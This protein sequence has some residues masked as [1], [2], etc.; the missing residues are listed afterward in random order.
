MDWIVYKCKNYSIIDFC[1][2][3]IYEINVYMIL[4]FFLEIINAIVFIYIDRFILVI[5]D[6]EKLNLF[7]SIPNYNYILR[8]PIGLK[9]IKMYP[10]LV[11]IILLVSLLEWYLLTRKSR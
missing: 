7:L 3:K 10:Q 11:V 9:K 2:I 8:M 5:F 6:E 4:Y 1:V